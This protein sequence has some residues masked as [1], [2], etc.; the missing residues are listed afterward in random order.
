MSIHVLHAAAS[1]TILLTIQQAFLHLYWSVDLRGN[2]NLP[3]KHISGPL[4]CYAWALHHIGVNLSPYKLLRLNLF[5][6]ENAWFYQ[7]IRHLL[8]KRTILHVVTLRGTQLIR[9]ALFNMAAQFLI[10]F[11]TIQIPRLCLR[12]F[13]I[14]CHLLSINLIIKIWSMIWFLCTVEI[15]SIDLWIYIADINR[16][17]RKLHLS[18]ISVR[19]YWLANGMVLVHLFFI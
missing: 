12:N 15:Y 13:F 17:C 14:K 7:R 3:C 1:S 8:L 10:K 16:F 5:E 4:K 6:W 11:H 9:N 18:A 2:R 19:I